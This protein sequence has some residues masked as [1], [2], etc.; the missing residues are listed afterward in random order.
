MVRRILLLISLTLGMVVSGTALSARASAC[1]NVDLLIGV[2]GEISGGG[3]DLGVESSQG[4][5]GSGGGEESAGDGGGSDQESG[6]GGDSG[7]SGGSGG[8]PAEPAC[9][10]QSR[11]LCAEMR[12]VIPDVVEAPTIT[13]VVTTREIAHLVPAVGTQGME[14]HGWMV[15]GLPTNFYAEVSPSVVSTTLLGSAAEVRFTPMSFLWDHGDGSTVTSENGGATWAALGVAEFSETSTSH[16][17]NRPGEYSM[18]LTVQYTAE[19]RIG[20]SPWRPLPGTVPSL[21]PPISASAKT[22]E[23]MLVADD[24]RRPRPSPGC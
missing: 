7:G 10:P 8:A 24:C 16:V 23:T 22:A 15:V 3:V 5:G 9:T 14:P 12:R 6:G 11:V 20:G 4:G 2:C 21:S 18:S 19:Y 1:T 13:P 17:Y